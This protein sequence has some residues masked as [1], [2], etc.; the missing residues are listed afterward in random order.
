M[1]QTQIR[2]LCCMDV[3]KELFDMTNLIP[4][5]YPYIESLYMETGGFK[6]YKNICF[7]CEKPSIISINKNNILHKDGGPCLRYEN[8][9]FEL[10]C[11]NGI[12]VPKDIAC[13][14]AE[15]LNPELL[16]TETNAEVRRQ[17]ILKIG[18]EKVLHDLNAKVLDEK[19]GYKLL[20]LK[21]GKEKR[22]RP[23]L[24]FMNATME[25]I[26]HIEGVSPECQTVEDALK[27]RNRL[28]VYNKPIQLT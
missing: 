16:F 9:N 21:L 13:I 7:I 4:P 12:I 11:L 22:I 10:Y 18:I 1:L 27:Y 26:Y 28:D 2:Y 15:Q 8:D 24:K 6:L 23:Y 5:S 3:Y 25:G 17:I 14:P 20:G 19:E